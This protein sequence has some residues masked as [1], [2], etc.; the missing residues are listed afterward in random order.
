MTGV[1]V[2][3]DSVGAIKAEMAS[4]TTNVT[5]SLMPRGGARLSRRG[6]CAMSC[7]SPN[8]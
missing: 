3:F 7:P 5:S 8:F 1:C 4:E 2:F 6:M